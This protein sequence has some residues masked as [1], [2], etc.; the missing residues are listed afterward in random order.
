[1]KQRLFPVSGLCYS[2]NVILCP[3]SSVPSRYRSRSIRIP[4]SHT[5]N[6]SN[7]QTV[8]LNIVGRR[9]RESAVELSH[10]LRIPDM[11]EDL[12]VGVP[13]HQ[14][15]ENPRICYYPGGRGHSL[16]WALVQP[17]H[18]FGEN[19]RICYY[20]GERGHSLVSIFGSV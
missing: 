19:P 4:F 6:I 20:P 7:D 5:K 10:H 1:M 14:F 8:I 18:Q 13:R 15:E 16:V 17:R 12:E 2:S 9:R 3:Y 11:G